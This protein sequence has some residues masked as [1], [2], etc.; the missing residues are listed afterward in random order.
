MISKKVFKKVSA[1]I[2]LVKQYKL[3]LAIFAVYLGVAE[4]KLAANA[5]FFQNITDKIENNVPRLSYGV[6][7]TDFNNDGKMEFIV[8]GFRYPN[9]AL[10]YVNGSYTNI[11]ARCWQVAKTH[12][13]ATT[14][15]RI[16]LQMGNPVR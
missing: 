11:K 10:S 13:V 9:L 4:N 1:F 8:A 6:A 12:Q 2:V 16:L 5:Q 14:Y 3:F 15:V 7:V